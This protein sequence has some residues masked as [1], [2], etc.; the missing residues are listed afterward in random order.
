[1]PRELFADRPGHAALRE[2]EEKP[3]KPDQ[4]R[5]KSLFSAIKHGT[6]F[7]RF[8]ANTMDASDRFDWEWRVHMR[9]EKV[10]EFP[11]PLGNMYVAEI[12]ELGEDASR[13]EVGDR[14]FGH[15]RLR[16][17]HTLWDER[18]EKVPEAAA[19]QTLMATDPAAS[20]FV[21][22]AMVISGWAIGS[23]CLDS[24]RLGR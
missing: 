6:E 8:Q 15:G 19:W 1:M 18:V 5:A 22:C 2:Y 9:G 4:V 24:G 16:E 11:K 21:G 17:T 13:V 12:T 10:D 20:R 7:R 14:V 23:R 3:L